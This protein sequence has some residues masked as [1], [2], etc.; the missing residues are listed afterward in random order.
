MLRA[1]QVKGVTNQGEKFLFQ[2][3]QPLGQLAGHLGQIG[4]I[5]LDAGHLHV[6]EHRQERQFGVFIQLPHARFLQAGHQ[7]FVELNRDVN[8]GPTI[9][10]HR[11]NRHLIDGDLFTPAANQLG[12]LSHLPG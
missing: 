8:I 5:E 4:E 1:A 2:R 3:R 10:P 12:D 6:G 9:G 7:L 11:S